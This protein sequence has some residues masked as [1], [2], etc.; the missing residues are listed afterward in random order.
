MCLNAS[1]Y[2]Y[3]AIKRGGWTL[4]G[5][6]GATER[7]SLVLTLLSPLM[8]SAMV[9]NHQEVNLQQFCQLLVSQSEGADSPRVRTALLNNL[10]METFSAKCLN[11]SYASNGE[12]GPVI[13][14][15]PV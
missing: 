9:T 6:P 10:L 15:R 7:A 5:G 14:Q 11:A 1:C 12:S 4:A 13:Q 2:S 8:F 3:Y